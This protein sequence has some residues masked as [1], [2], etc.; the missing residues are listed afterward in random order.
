MPY[1]FGAVNTDDLSLPIASSITG[2]SV[3]GMLLIWVY[4]TT[5][6]AGRAIAGFG[7]NLG[8]II[9][10]TTTSELD[11][12][13]GAATTDGVWTSSG[14]GLATGSWRFLAFAWT[15]IAGPTMEVALWAGDG[16]TPP[17]A[18]TITQTTAP[19]GTF[20]SQ[21]TMS[22]G[23]TAT[24]ATTAWQGDIGP[25][26][27]IST[28]IAAGATH[29]FGQSAYGAFG[30]DSI[31]MMYSRFVRPIWSGSYRQAQV[32]KV[33]NN[34]T[35]M[36]HVS[37]DMG[38]QT[39]AY[40]YVQTSSANDYPGAPTFNGITPAASQAPNPRYSLAGMNASIRRR[41]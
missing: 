28:G 37:C 40:R 34:T 5:L 6:T 32:G 16:V 29:P 7:N 12:A 30:A 35:S 15:A 23:A 18:V 31:E 41:R 2:A 22:I 19:V 27:V 21:S 11:V 33:I 10:N 14:L 36:Q 1:T 13:L 39:A 17:V 3:S 24:A 9:I 26:D 8:R 38:L 4:P 20:S 25:L